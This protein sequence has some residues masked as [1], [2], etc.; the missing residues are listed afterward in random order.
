MATMETTTQEDTDLF[1][2][3]LKKKIGTLNGTIP[4]SA[5]DLE[6]V[7]TEDND[8]MEDAGATTIGY[9]SIKDY[10]YEDSNPLHYGYFDGD[11]EEY[12]MVSDSSNTDDEYNKRQSITL[13]DDYIVNQRAVAL[14]DFEPEN[15]NELKLTEG[16]IVFISYKHGQG[17]LVAENESRSKTGLVP[18][19]FVSYIQPEDGVEEQE[20]TARPF[21]LTHL[22]T[23]SVNPEKND[24][25][26]DKNDDDE[27]EDIDDV[28]DVE[29]DVRTKL[30]ISN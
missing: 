18:E 28:A 1:K 7:Q 29:T 16:D 4:Q 20:D 21:Y 12:E 26:N 9:I 2:A 15:D 22:I 6:L 25:N 17:W 8:K 30:N 11:N 19:E 3:G 5:R 14:Y 13:P 24:S 23:Q 10:A 27:W